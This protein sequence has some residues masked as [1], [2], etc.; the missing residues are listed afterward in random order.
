MNIGKAIKICR[1]KKKLSQK[2]LAKKA[3]IS[4][5]YLSLLERSKREANLSVI[6]NITKAL[7]IPISI[8]IFLAADKKELA[9]LNNGL[10][11][12]LSNVAL[13]LMNNGDKK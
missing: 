13:E 2:D 5:S 6:T 4:I 11:D 7:D 10:I 8:L 12:K 1:H 3:K 9:G